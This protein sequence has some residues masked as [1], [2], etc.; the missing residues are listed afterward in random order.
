MIEKNLKRYFNKKINFSRNELYKFFLLREPGLNKNTFAWRIY[1]LKKKG[2]IREIARGQY[3]F[4]D[5]KD[6]FLHLT[7]YSVKIAS[8]ISKN[9]PDINFCLSESTWINEFTKH[10]Y[11]NNFIVVEIEKDFLEPVFFYLKEVFK[12]VFL[13]PNKKEFDRY[14]TGLDKVIILTPFITRSPVKKFEN[15]KFN[16][17]VIEKLLVDIFTKRSP[18]YFIANSEVK[19]VFEKA[20]RKYNI[21]QT[22][23]LA[24]AERRGKKK[25]IKNFLIENKLLAIVND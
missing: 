8:G 13:K 7:N 19:T 16:I 20:F 10:Q 17:P 18:Y 9:F 4:I 23:L 14:I 12:N 25:E 6:Y 11:S 15:K 5:K 21:N 24:Y 3:S 22:T 2:I 1:N